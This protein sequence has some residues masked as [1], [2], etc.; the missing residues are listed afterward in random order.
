MDTERLAMVKVSQQSSFTYFHAESVDAE[1]LAVVKLSLPTCRHG[2]SAHGPYICSVILG[3]V[4]TAP[5]ADRVG[6]GSVNASCL[7]CA[8]MLVAYAGSHAATAKA[9]SV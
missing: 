8:R 1:R 7:Y 9:C 4:C 2:L 3:T 6:Y 5:E